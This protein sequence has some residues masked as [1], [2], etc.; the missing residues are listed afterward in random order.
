MISQ[1]DPGICLSRLLRCLLLLRWCSW[2]VAI[3]RVT[4]GAKSAANGPTV[5]SCGKNEQLM[6]HSGAA[7]LSAVATQKLLCQNSADDSMQFWSSHRAMCWG[8]SIPHHWKHCTFLLSKRPM[9]AA[10]SWDLHHMP[11]KNCSSH[12]PA[13]K[14]E[15]WVSSYPFRN[16]MAIHVSP[17]KEKAECTLSMDWDFICTYVH[18]SVNNISFDA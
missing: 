17:N 18:S 4:S 10:T 15:S 5:A 16:Y 8:S 11:S 6:R 2:A 3:M 14:A 1:N 12:A 9:E 7:L 13:V